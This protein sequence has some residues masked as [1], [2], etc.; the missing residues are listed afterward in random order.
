[1]KLKNLFSRN[2]F[3]DSQYIIKE[4]FTIGGTTYYEFDDPF[5]MGCIRGMTAIRFYKEMEMGIDDAYI[6]KHIEATSKLLRSNPI[7]VFEIDKLNKQLKERNEFI[8]DTDLV[9]KLASVVYFD[10]NEKPELYEEAYNLKKIEFWKKH[11]RVGA[12]FLRQPIQKLV[13]YL[14][15]SDIDIQSYSEAVQ[16]IKQ[17][18]LE[19]AA[20]TS[21]LTKQMSSTKA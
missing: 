4:A 20:L 12:F 11:E 16:A 19:N 14:T 3:P 15:L 1:M 21:S 17:L 2:P 10:K 6:K 18:H 9:Y 13:P 8:I 5:N 7:D